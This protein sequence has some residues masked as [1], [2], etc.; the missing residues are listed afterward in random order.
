MF[1]FPFE[2]S[3]ANILLGVDLCFTCPLKVTQIFDM[4][5]VYLG[6]VDALDIHSF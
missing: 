3:I 6:N 2:K 5:G 4:G 1:I